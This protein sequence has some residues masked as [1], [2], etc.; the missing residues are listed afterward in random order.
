[1]AS[2]SCKKDGSKLDLQKGLVS[3]F[4]FDDNL[5]D[6][7]GYF[8][9]GVGFPKFLS[10]KG[11]S[12]LSFDGV[13]QKLVLTPKVPQT[14]NLFTIS[15]W[16]SSSGGAFLAGQMNQVEN[17]SIF[18]GSGL[19]FCNNKTS[20]NTY[21]GVNFSGFPFQ[22]WAYLTLTYDGK[23]MKVYLDGV[24]KASND[25][26][27]FNSIQDQTFTLGFSSQGYAECMIDELR[28]YNRALSQAEVTELYNLK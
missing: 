16:V 19:I 9:E 6:Q 12:A 11:G 20:I 28:L 7:Q 10:V 22:K 4:N 26:V 27:S 3:Y 13:N 14:S 15:F 1:M 17:F 5:I 23:I 8:E 21:D 18:Y 24:F 25:T 2:M